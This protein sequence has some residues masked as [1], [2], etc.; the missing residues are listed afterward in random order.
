[1]SGA[2][3]FS[4][5]ARFRAAPVTSF[6]DDH[7]FLA[8]PFPC[9]VV[10]EGIE[11]PGGEW[12]FQAAKT[13]DFG[14]RREIATLGSWQ[15]AKAA[16]RAIRLRPDW[17]QVKRVV[18]M[19]VVMDKFTRSPALGA[20]LAAT[21][22]RVLVEGNTWG[23]SYWGAVP[24]RPRTAREWETLGRTPVW[25]TGNPG[26]ILAGHNWLGWILM[27]TRELIVMDPVGRMQ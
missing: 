10:Y 5:T 8:N 17:E 1:M 4:D 23:D 22:E 24:F 14:L 2:L 11:F 3:A 9:P 26:E 20:A 12:A 18:M 25:Q 15:E 6:R 19:Q 27:M 13:P 7:W 21:G 16:G